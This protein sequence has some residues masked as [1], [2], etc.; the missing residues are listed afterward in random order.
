ML[1]KID[2][3]VFNSDPIKQL[4]IDIHNLSRQLGQIGVSKEVTEEWLVDFL[5]QMPI[6]DAQP[7]KDYA[8]R[9]FKEVGI[10]ILASKKR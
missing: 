9:R 7:R 3:E 10:E 6:Y 1:N 8:M 2:K 5:R 4:S